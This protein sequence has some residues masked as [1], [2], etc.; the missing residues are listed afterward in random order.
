MKKNFQKNKCKDNMCIHWDFEFSISS[1]V[2][3]IPD[4][5]QAYLSPLKWILILKKTQQNNL[6]TE[7]Y[8]WE[9]IQ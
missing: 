9:R 2:A 6:P 1:N 3:V 7:F 8:C 5:S 4:S